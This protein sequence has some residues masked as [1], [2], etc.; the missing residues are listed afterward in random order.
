MSFTSFSEPRLQSYSSFC[1]FV[2]TI[3]NREG[4]LPYAEY[5][6]V[7]DTAAV[8]KY[9]LH[10]R[11]V[12]LIACCSGLTCL[13]LGSQPASVEIDFFDFIV[14]YCPRLEKLQLPDIEKCVFMQEWNFSSLKRLRSIDLIAAPIDASFVTSLP[15]EVNSV[16]LERIAIDNMY[17]EKL[18]K[19][20]PYIRQLE[21]VQCKGISNLSGID[22]AESLESIIIS[23][24]SVTDATIQPLWS[25]NRNLT[26]C[27]L[28]DT[29]ITDTTLIAI[30][31]SNI[32]I[33]NLNISDCS[34]ISAEGVHTLLLAN[35]PPKCVEVTNCMQ[36]L[37]SQAEYLA[38]HSP[39]GT[40]IW[41]RRRKSFF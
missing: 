39:K 29:N 7:L 37:T 21:L 31:K 36:I 17:L 28:Q 23:G 16:R 32:C 9:D 1:G 33:D 35:Q 12:K 27:S 2:R 5:V 6:R 13:S 3:T 10:R 18:L 20:H 24:S 34:R 41:S 38:N 26:V 22:F 11:L 25:L 19:T 4:I 15:K 40:K 14:G 30:S 8:N